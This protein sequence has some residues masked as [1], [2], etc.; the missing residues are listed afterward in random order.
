MDQ[1]QHP[2]VTRTFTNIA[3]GSNLDLV[4][5]RPGYSVAHGGPALSGGADTDSYN[6]DVIKPSRI[7]FQTNGDVTLRYYCGNDRDTGAKLYYDD[8]L[9]GFAGELLDFT[10][11]VIVAATTTA[12]ITVGWPR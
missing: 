2:T 1:R 9:T 3:A 11:D 6:V 10:P 4:T 12:D 5:S 7:R 8:T